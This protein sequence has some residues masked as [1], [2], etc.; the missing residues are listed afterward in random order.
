[1][2]TKKKHPDLLGQHTIVSQARSKVS[3]FASQLDKF[4][5][6]F[7]SLVGVVVLSKTKAG[8]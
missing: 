2:S 5:K 4:E 3:G 1:M 8:I 7:Q 6:N